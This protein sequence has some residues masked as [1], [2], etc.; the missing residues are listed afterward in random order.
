MIDSAMALSKL[1]PRDPTED[2]APF[3]ASRSV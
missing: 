1:S 2:T 3:S